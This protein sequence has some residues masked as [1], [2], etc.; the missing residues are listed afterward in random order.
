[1][2][3]GKQKKLTKTMNCTRMYSRTEKKISKK[4]K[5][6]SV[7]SNGRRKWVRKNIKRAEAKTDRSVICVRVPTE[8]AHTRRS[9]ETNWTGL[10][11]SEVAEWWLIKNTGMARVESFGYRYGSTGGGVGFRGR[12]HHKSVLLKKFY[13]IKTQHLK[14]DINV[15]YNG[16]LLFWR[17]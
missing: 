9:K 14:I 12:G 7:Q 13:I 8:P 3:Y 15:I 11:L 5:N 2:K 10:R 16:I 6:G 17:W 4:T 1:M